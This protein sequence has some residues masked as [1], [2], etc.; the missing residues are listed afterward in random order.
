LEGRVFE[1]KR[2]THTGKQW[3]EFHRPRDFKLM[4]TKTRIV[5]PTLIKR[6]RFSLD[7]IGYLSD[8][9]CL[10]LQPTQK[11]NEN[12]RRLREQLAAATG[13]R[14]TL[15]DVLK[16]CLAFLNSDYAQHRFVTGHRPTPKGFYAMT[17]AVLREIPI[18]PPDA[19]T[20]T[21]ILKLVTQLT[22]AETEAETEKLEKKLAQITG[23]LLPV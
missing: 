14:A 22:K 4:L 10:Y 1:K 6:L 15:E 3:Y 13:K 20:A 16:Y 21:T 7:T 8:H 11:T 18:A 9:A 12:Y 5:S 17:E 2:F 23:T 19:R